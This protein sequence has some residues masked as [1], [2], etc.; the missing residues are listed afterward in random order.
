MESSNKEDQIYMAI[1]MVPVRLVVSVVVFYSIVLYSTGPLPHP[2]AEDVGPDGHS[3]GRERGTT[4][5]GG[6][7]QGEVGGGA[8]ATPQPTGMQGRMPELLLED[9]HIMLARLLTITKQ[10][11]FFLL[12]NLKTYFLQCHTCTVK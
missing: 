6:G 7:T 4:R 3:R 1:S 9:L 10:P 8:P 12:D 2:P 11:L 5:P